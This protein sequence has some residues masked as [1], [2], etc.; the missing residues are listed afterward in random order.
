MHTILAGRFQEIEQANAAMQALRDAGFGAADMTSFFVNPRGQHDLYPVGGDADDS[1]QAHQAPQG[2]GA[3]SAIGGVVGA[4]I[5][6]AAVPLVG[7]GAAVA[8]AAV[9]AGVGAYAGSLIGT[10]NRLGEPVS[11]ADDNANQK[12]AQE[13]C[14]PRKAGM[15]VAVAA[16]DALLQDKALDV[17]RAQGAVDLERNSGRIEAGN[18]TDFDPLRPLHLVR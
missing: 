3:G 2:L 18:W 16:D 8:G 4:A 9:A 13:A 6:V 1:A 11:A 10:L 15:L 17:L 5:G 14:P 12:S 7:P